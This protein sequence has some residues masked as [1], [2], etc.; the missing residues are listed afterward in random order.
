MKKNKKKKLI[1]THNAGF[2]TDDVF[3]VATLELLLG[4]DVE[5]IRTRD[6]DIIKTGDYVVDVGGVYDEETNRFDHHQKGGAGKRENG[7]PYAAF[8][9]VWKKFGKEVCGSQ[10]VADAID[11]KIAQYVDAGDNGVDTHKNIFPGLGQY[12]IY[13]IINSYEPTWKETEKNTDTEFLN[14]ADFAKSL[15]KREIK[16]VTDWVEAENNVKEIYKNTDNKQL[17]ILDKN[18]NYSRVLISLTLAG[19][20]EPLYFVH[21]RISDNL[22]QVVTINKERSTLELRKALPEEWKGS[23]MEEFSKLTGISDGVFCHIY[24]FMCVTKSKES[25]VKLAKLA[26]EA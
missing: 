19:F 4:D 15:L 22:W 26:L 5:V 17:I 23:E 1:I 3:A 8:G 18:Y 6:E 11:K 21:H 14:A 13:Q 24:G 9:L 20:P 2:H 16:S 25:A 10:A 12:D 7:I